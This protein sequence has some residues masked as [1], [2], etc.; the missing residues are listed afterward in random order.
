MITKIVK[1]EKD[2][3]YAP[4]I[5]L[6]VKRITDDINI[7]FPLFQLNHWEI[8]PTGFTF[9]HQKYNKND[10]K[11]FYDVYEHEYLELQKFEVK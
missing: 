6:Y 8:T 5:K 4:I 3:G 2:Y 10:F 9:R 7:K 1:F 11:F